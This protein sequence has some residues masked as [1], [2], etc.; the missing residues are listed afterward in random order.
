MYSRV[1]LANKSRKIC[2]TL[3]AILA[4]KLVYISTV[5][6]KFS[7]NCK[8]IFSAAKRVP[9]IVET[10][11]T[12]QVTFFLFF[13]LPIFSHFYFIFSLSFFLVIYWST[14]SA[15][16]PDIRFEP[17][18]RRSGFYSLLFSRVC[19]YMTLFPLSAHWSKRN[20]RPLRDL[21]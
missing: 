20:T 12:R 7:L 6:R 5:G 1:W 15:L 11:Y 8:Q 19:V 3:G 4:Q 13:Y 18:H 9:I 10:L 2:R 21:L 17:I 14:S 16:L